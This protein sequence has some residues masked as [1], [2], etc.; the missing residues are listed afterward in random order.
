MEV[1][2]I[3]GYCVALLMTLQWRR[4]ELDGVPNYQ[5][6]D[7]LLNRFFIHISKKASKLCV[8]G[9]C[10]GNSPVTGEFPAQRASYAENFFI[11]WRHHGT[12]FLTT[13]FKLNYS[14]TNEQ[15]KHN[16]SHGRLEL[17][18]SRPVQNG[19]HFTDKFSNV[20]LN[21]N[22]SHFSTHCHELCS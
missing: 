6:Q 2:C 17:A 14:N 9:L 11:W 20:F 5:P 13:S 10:E 21:I 16:C 7:C 8:T 18:T 15:M 22:V 3:G 19:R 1:Y 12:E 4:N